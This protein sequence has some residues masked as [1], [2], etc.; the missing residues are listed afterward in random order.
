LRQGIDRVAETVAKRGGRKML[1]FIIKRQRYD[2]TCLNALFTSFETVDCEVP[3]LEDAL[4][5]GGCGGGP[6]GDAFDRPELLNVEVLEPG[7]RPQ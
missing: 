4:R 5:Q 2:G 1:R 7:E 3:K 6:N